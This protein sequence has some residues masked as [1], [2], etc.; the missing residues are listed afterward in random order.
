MAYIY[1]FSFRFFLFACKGWTK[2]YEF[3][4]SDLRTASEI[5]VRLCDDAHRRKTPIRWEDAHGLLSLAV[6]G[7]RI[8][9]T[10]DARVLSSYLAQYFSSDVI[11]DAS[12]SRGK[13]NQLGPGIVVPAS[14]HYDDYI[15]LIRNLSEQVRRLGNGTG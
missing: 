3:S 15:Q 11:S 14:N 7:G 6:Y 5:I 8:D 1:S 13:V 2:F 9:N 10:F 4:T 12:R